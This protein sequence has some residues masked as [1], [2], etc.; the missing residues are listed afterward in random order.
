MCH[1]TQPTRCANTPAVG[2]IPA[3]PAGYLP[4]FRHCSPAPC[5]ELPILRIVSGGTTGALYGSAVTPLRMKLA[6]LSVVAAIVATTGGSVFAQAIHPVCVAK[7]H[8]CGK[9]AKISKCCCGDQEAAWTD[10][11]PVQPRVEV[12]ADLL[13]TP[14]LP[15]VVHI[16]PAPQALSPVQTSPP[17]LC[18]LDLPTLFSTFLI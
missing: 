3:L 8:D 9:T 7:Q 2:E 11:T 17:R 18:L 5:Q 6:A 1:S 12:R 13:A 15:N 4:D 16:A 10:S 14:A